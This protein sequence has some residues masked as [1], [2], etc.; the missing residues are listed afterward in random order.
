MPTTSWSA[1]LISTTCDEGQLVARFFYTFFMRSRF[2]ILGL[3]KSE[4]WSRA[5]MTLV[6]ISHLHMGGSSS[7]I[8]QNKKEAAMW[9]GVHGLET[10]VVCAGGQ[11]GFSRR[12]LWKGI[13]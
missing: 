10:E 1:L 11:D 6:R 2:Q 9:P 7:C 8:W 5:L 3:P 4:L 12:S 13:E